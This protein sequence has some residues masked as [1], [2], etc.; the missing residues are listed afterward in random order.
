MRLFSR[1]LAKW[2][3]TSAEGTFVIAIPLIPRKRAKD[4]DQILSK[5]QAT[6][7]STLGQTDPDFRIIICTEDEIDLPEARHPKVRILLY[8]AGRPPSAYKNTH[9]LAIQD[10]YARRMRLTDEAMRI[11]ARHLMFLDADDLVSN[12]LVETI[13][14]L[15]FSCAYALSSGFVMDDA[16][17]KVALCPSELIKISHFDSFCGSSW[18]FSLSPQSTLPRGWLRLVKNTGHHQV[19]EA[20]SAS[21]T[22]IHNI[23]QP[24]AIYLLNTGHNMSG[25]GTSDSTPGYYGTNGAAIAAKHGRALTPEESKEFGFPNSL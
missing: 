17:K 10:A 25:A 12:R 4:W 9:T 11:S 5:L 16:T 7:R 22:S 18:V 3:K 1:L 24:L 14:A 19:R 6:L 20:L 21:G 8:G 23:E 15:P 13:K 2:N